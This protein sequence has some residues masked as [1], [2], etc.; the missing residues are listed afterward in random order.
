MKISFPGGQKVNAIFNQFEVKTDQPIESGGE[1]TAPTPFSLF[2]SSIGTCTGIYILRFCQERN[3]PTEDLSLIMKA[4]W[5]EKIKLI[6][7]IEISI[8]TGKLF[9]KKYKNTLIKVAKLCTV[10]RHLEN[11]P[12]INIKVE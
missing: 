6:E 8:N 10:K 4:Q 11:P 7:T 12:K 3:L 9:P 2:L 1:S 5:N